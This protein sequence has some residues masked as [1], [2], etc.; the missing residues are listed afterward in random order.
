VSADVPATGRASR[1]LASAAVLV[2]LEAVALL[3]VAVSVLVSASGSRAVLDLTTSLF[4]VACAGALLACAR[5]L[6][7]SRA[8]ARGPVVFAQL[9]QF[10]LAWSFYSGSTRPVAMLLVGVAV[11]VLALVLSPASTRA[12]GLDPPEH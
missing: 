9:I 4:F 10:L 8:W 6:W 12:L 11:L 5:G 2:C 1:R 3:A 7:R